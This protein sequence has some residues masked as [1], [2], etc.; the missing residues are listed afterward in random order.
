MACLSRNRSV[1]QIRV[2]HMRVRITLPHTLEARSILRRLCV[3][4]AAG[5]SCWMTSAMS[6]RSRGRITEGPK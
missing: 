5:C 2:A 1:H 4:T 6:A 3:V